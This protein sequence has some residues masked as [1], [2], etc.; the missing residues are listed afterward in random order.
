M[1]EKEFESR[2]QPFRYD[3][4]VVIEPPFLAEKRLAENSGVTCVIPK[5]QWAIKI[6]WLERTADGDDDDDDEKKYKYCVEDTPAM[7]A[8]L[9]SAVLVQPVVMLQG[10]VELEKT[11]LPIQNVE[12]VIKRTSHDVIMNTNLSRFSE[13]H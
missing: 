12:R 6:E 4:A 3:L 9:E 8:L 1:S 5:G 2:D 13:Y 10:G 11:S 7:V